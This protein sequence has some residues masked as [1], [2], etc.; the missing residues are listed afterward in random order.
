[1][2]RNYSSIQLFKKNRKIDGATPEQF[3]QED[4]PKSEQR[5]SERINQP[6]ESKEK[7]T[8]V[9]SNSE[10]SPL[11]LN[12]TKTIQTVLS[13]LNMDRKNDFKLDLIRDKGILKWPIWSI[14]RKSK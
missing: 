5:L 2:N 12:F 8:S 13:I 11:P 7:E 14:F 3:T 4:L 1:M 6:L 9:L 10:Q